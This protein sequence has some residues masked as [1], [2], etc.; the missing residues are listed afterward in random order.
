MMATH[1]VLRS[2]V[3]VGVVLAFVQCAERKASSQL[4]DRDNPQDIQALKCS[5]CRSSSSIVKSHLADAVIEFLHHAA[6]DEATRQMYLASAV[7]GTCENEQINV[8]LL[9]KPDK[10]RVLPTFQHEL[11]D[12][13]SG[14]LVK[15]AWITQL[16]TEQCFEMIKRMEP[17]FLQFSLGKEFDWCPVCSE[18]ATTDN[19]DVV[20][21]RHEDL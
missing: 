1:I 17:N 7:P 12:D 21:S 10:Q 20:S 2:I 9:R 11:R 14:D 3:I 13:Y 6:P 8:G 19:R 4:P 15:A 16:W 5:A 18:E